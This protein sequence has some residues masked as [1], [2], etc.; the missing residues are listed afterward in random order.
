MDRTNLLVQLNA[1]FETYSAEQ[2]Y[3]VSNNNPISVLWP[4]TCEMTP[5]L[6]SN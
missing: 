1:T 2:M 6:A 4:N 3:L 5:Q